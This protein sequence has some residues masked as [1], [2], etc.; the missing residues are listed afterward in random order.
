MLAMSFFDT[1]PIGRIINRFSRDMNNIDSTVPD[2][3]VGTIRMFLFCLGVTVSVA[4]VTPWFLSALIPMGIFYWWVQK[5]FIATSRELR[6]ISNLQNSPIFSH[7]SESASGYMIIRA[8]SAV[9]R[10]ST[11]NKELID[12]DHQAY[13]P[14]VAANRW[15]AIRLEFIGNT[16]LGTTALLCAIQRYLIIFFL[17]LCVCVFNLSQV[18]CIY[19]GID[20]LV[21]GMSLIFDRFENL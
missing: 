5:Y 8:F 7:F 2:S 11:K 4:V 12:K 3:F 19:V 17:S 10:F 16:L 15:L 6:R 1:T 20:L 18:L 14:S 9:D 21:F 13:Y